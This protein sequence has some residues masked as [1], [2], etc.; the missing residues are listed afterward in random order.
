MVVL[1]IVFVV[2]LKTLPLHTIL[3]WAGPHDRALAASSSD[4][5]ILVLI[6]GLVVLGLWLVTAGIM[7]LVPVRH[8]LVPHSA[9]WKSGGRHP[10]MRRRYA[11]YLGRA[12]G[13]T[14]VFIAA[15]LLL[16]ILSQKGSALETPWAPIVVSIA[17]IVG[18]LIFAVWVFTDGFRPAPTPRSSGT[19]AVGARTGQ[20]S[21]RR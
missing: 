17:Y 4:V 15:E 8:V 7:A 3:I 2:G 11:A 9:Y 18:L 12:V 19:G 14:Y 5:E 16:G 13:G 10:E 21:A 1:A 6:A 20:T